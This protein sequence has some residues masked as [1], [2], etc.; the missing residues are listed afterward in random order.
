MI[1]VGQE[2]IL[3]TLLEL[4]SNGGKCFIQFTG[5]GSFVFLF[6]DFDELLVD[7]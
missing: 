4:Y 6:Y 3:F 5:E 1:D 2:Y 7:G